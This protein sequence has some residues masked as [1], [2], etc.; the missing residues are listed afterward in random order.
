MPE[1]N[2]EVMENAVETTGTNPA[3]KIVIIALSAV[4]AIGAAFI[5]KKVAPKLKA[6]FSHGEQSDVV[7]TVAEVSTNEA[8]DFVEIGTTN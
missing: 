2:V 8:K 5:T 1:N 4:A 6:K 3:T 7:E